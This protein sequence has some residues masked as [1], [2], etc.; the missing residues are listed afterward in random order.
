MTTR[1]CLNDTVQ[2]TDRAGDRN[3]AAPPV[4]TLEA[5][6]TRPLLRVG[7]ADCVHCLN[8]VAAALLAPPHVRRVPTNA[9]AGCMA[10]DHAGDDIVALKDLVKRQLHGIER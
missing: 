4:S 6:M 8:D 10:I 9:V 5:H 1:P 2:I 7:H 3:G